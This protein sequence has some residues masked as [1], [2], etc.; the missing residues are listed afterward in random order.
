M[1]VDIFYDILGLMTLY[2]TQSGSKTMHAKSSLT[3]WGCVTVNTV[4]YMFEVIHGDCTF[5]TY[6][7]GLAQSVIY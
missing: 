7:L 6:S 1:V 5:S 4:P 3:N 2:N